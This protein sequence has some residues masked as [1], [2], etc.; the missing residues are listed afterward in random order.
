MTMP[1]PKTHRSYALSNLA[2]LPTRAGIGFKPQHLVD[3]LDD[4]APPGFIEVHAENY[5]GAG[6]LAHAH[7]TRLRERFPLSLHGVG[8]SIGGPEPLDEAHLATLSALIQRYEPASFSEHLAWSSHGGSYFN[9]LLPL[10]YTEA[11][12]QLVCDHVDRVQERLGHKMLLENPA[13][14]IEF[15]ASDID[16]TEFIREVVRRTGCGLL[17]DVNNLHV[18]CT[19]HQR[20]AEAYL[21]ALPLHAVGEIHLAG[22][23]IDDD[24]SGLLLI[25]SHGAPVAGAV[26]SIYARALAETGPVASLI[27]WDND[28]PDYATLRAESRKADLMLAA[29]QSPKPTRTN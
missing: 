3:L 24:P 29:I 19:N 28:V 12:L 11:S 13:T 2:G 5:F 27:E 17:L 22:H 4:L 20:D 10:I 18:T 25:D 21:A 14:Y 8:L 15:V 1:S 16:E 7:L 26:W 9:D 23:A 6:G